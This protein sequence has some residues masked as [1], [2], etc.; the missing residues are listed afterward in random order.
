MPVVWY[1]IRWWVWC[2]SEDEKKGIDSI[3]TDKV[4]EC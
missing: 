4:E 3:F 2:M 1:S